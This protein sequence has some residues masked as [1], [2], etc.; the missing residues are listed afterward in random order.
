[1]KNGCL[2]I[3][4]I[5]LGLSFWIS[6]SY[7]YENSSPYYQEG[8]YDPDDPFTQLQYE[9]ARE[10]F[11]DKP[12]PNREVVGYD[13]KK[14]EYKYRDQI[15]KDTI[16]IVEPP[17]MPDYYVA[18]VPK[19]RRTREPYYEEEI[20]VLRGGKRYRVNQKPDGTLELIPI[21]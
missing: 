14:M 4:L 16:P 12:D 11:Q 20:Q 18:P 9:Q 15:P 19:Q 7:D 3:I 10:E 8:H 5:A 17:P 21:R 6:L 1:M 13:W 2:I